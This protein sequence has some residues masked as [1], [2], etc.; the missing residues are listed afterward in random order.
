M[1]PVIQLATSQAQVRHC[2]PF[3]GVNRDTL[4]GLLLYPIEAKERFTDLLHMHPAL[5]VDVIS[6]SV[7]CLLPR[8]I[9]T[10]CLWSWSWST[11]GQP[12][13]CLQILIIHVALPWVT[14][15]CSAWFMREHLATH[16]AVPWLLA[17]EYICGEGLKL[18]ISVL[19]SFLQPPIISPL[20]DPNSRSTLACVF[21]LSETKA[22]THTNLLAK[23]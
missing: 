23:L 19:C 9:V 15:W 11:C 6:A 16:T 1:F 5:H 22:Y 14:G 7:A 8:A 3:C 2:V 13:R 4:V 10:R 20:L 18:W 12:L 17:F 21:S